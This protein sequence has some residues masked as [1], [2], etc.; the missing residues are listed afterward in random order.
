MKLRRA[1]PCTW[2]DDVVPPWRPSGSPQKDKVFLRGGLGELSSEARLKGFKT[3][4]P[5][6]ARGLPLKGAARECGDP[7]PYLWA[8]G[9]A[10][11]PFGDATPHVAA[12]LTVHWTVEQNCAAPP[13]HGE[14]GH[15][16][17]SV[18]GGCRIATGGG[19]YSQSLRVAGSPRQSAPHL[20]PYRYLNVNP[21]NVFGVT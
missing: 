2:R 11:K 18:G 12:Q 13:S 3:P 5:S 7:H 1:T 14:G 15:E 16:P 20:V 6:R 4:F 19:A 9:T 17:P 10:A 8:A 21:N